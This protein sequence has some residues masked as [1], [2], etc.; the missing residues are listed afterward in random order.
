M[1]P[2]PALVVS[3]QV[4]VARLRIFL[5]ALLLWR[6]YK[7][8]LSLREFSALDGNDFMVEG[9]NVQP[10]TFDHVKNR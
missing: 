6:E 8:N 3:L 10:L 5:A 9:S 1:N 4:R 7:V 2:L